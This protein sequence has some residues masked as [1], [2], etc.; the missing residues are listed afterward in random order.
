MVIAEVEEQNCRDKGEEEMERLCAQAFVAL[1][2]FCIMF[3]RI[4]L[5]SNTLVF[6]VT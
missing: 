5:P 6:F 2:G 3:L 4:E 1:V